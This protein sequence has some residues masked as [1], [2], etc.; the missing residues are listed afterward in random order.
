MRW[1]KIGR[2]L[3]LCGALMVTFGLSTLPA[4]GAE[5]APL[6]HPR[7]APSPRPT[8]GPTSRQ[9][10]GG[11]AAP[12]EGRITG[13]IINL[14][15]GAPVPGVPVK[16]G[17]AVIL[18]DANGNYDLW[19]L[20]GPYSVALALN[21]E[22]GI[23]DQVQ[24]VVD[25]V[26]NQTT[27]LHLNFRAQPT[28]SVAPS[29]TSA[30]PKATATAVK[31]TAVEGRTR[32][33]AAPRL[34]RTA[35]QESNAW[36]WMLFG[37]LLVVGGVALEYGRTRR[38]PPPARATASANRTTAGAG[39]TRTG[40]DNARLLARLLASD[41]QNTRPVRARAT[42]SELLLAALLTADTGGD[43]RLEIRD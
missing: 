12:A 33:R 41:L 24:Q 5:S 25:I 7:L 17:D 32:P 29:A 34:P 13:T 19:V 37:A 8:L 6:P 30:A 35:A 36:F 18:S 22:Q 1:H 27:I 42:E 3:A 23:P 11:E 40:Y 31:P 14:T 9:R 10:G 38:P 43:Q 26:A 16:I 28:P 4:Q 21:P 39:R 2:I 15:T 20:P